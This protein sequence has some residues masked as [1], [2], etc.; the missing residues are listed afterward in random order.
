[1]YAQAVPESPAQ[2]LTAQ[3]AV[4]LFVRDLADLDK[5]ETQSSCSGCPGALRR[6]APTHLSLDEEV[7]DDRFDALLQLAPGITVS[8][9]LPE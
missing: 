2:H 6:D 5:G 8:G 9:E 1:M 3:E 7:V 4:W